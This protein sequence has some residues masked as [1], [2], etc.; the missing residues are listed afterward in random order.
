MINI[1]IST[2]YLFQQWSIFCNQIMLSVKY[3]KQAGAELC[4]AQTQ[5]GLSAEAELLTDLGFPGEDL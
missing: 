2:Q 3:G 1:N 4:Q 5:L